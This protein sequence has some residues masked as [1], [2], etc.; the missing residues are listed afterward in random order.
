LHTALNASSGHSIT[1][2][3]K[4]LRAF[5]NT[6]I[7]ALSRLKNLIYDASDKSDIFLHVNIVH[8]LSNSVRCNKSGVLLLNLTL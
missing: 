6:G 1:K 2:H 4:K 3:D 8:H 7:T 5:L